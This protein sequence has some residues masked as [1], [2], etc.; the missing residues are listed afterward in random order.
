MDLF[1]DTHIDLDDILNFFSV[2]PRHCDWHGLSS[3][4]G[5][6]SGTS[7]EKV[8]YIT[9]ILRQTGY[10]NRAEEGY[11]KNRNYVMMI[12]WS[13]EGINLL[14]KANQIIYKV[15]VIQELVKLFGKEIL[16]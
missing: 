8:R 15:D 4:F 13:G 7:T 6:V 9:S 2:F 12:E 14:K 5:G 3:H 11:Q 10:I 16:E 1:T